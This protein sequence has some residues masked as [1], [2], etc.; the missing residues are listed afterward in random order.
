MKS[1]LRDCLE[2]WRTIYLDACANCA[3]KVSKRDIKTTVSRVEEEGMSFLTITLPNFA[4]DFEYSLEH[5]MVD[6]TLFR[7]FRKTAAIPAFLQGMLGRIFHRD[8]GRINDDKNINSPN[9]TARLVA[10][11]RQICL[12][13]KKIE[14]PCTPER[15]FAALEN[16]IAV[17]NSFELFTLSGEDVEAFAS[18]SS[19]LW[20]DVLRDLRMDLLL[21]RHGPGA[22]SERISGNQKFR[23]KFWHDRLEPFLSL[24]SNAYP[25][26]LW[27]RR[28]E[29]EELERVSILSS[30]CELPVR[31]T[32]VPKTLKGPRI[33]AIEPCCMQYAQQGLRSIIYDAIERHRW[34]SGHINFRDQS[35]NQS[36][37]IR[38]SID[39]SLSTI[40][41]SDASDRVPLS[42]AL[43]MFDSVPDIRDFINAC[44]STHAKMPDGRIVGPL[45]KF[46]S[47]GSALCFPVEAMYFYTIC[48]VALT[49]GADLPVDYGTIRS[50]CRNIY[51]YGDDIIVPTDMTATVL[52]Y[53]KKYNCKV[54][55]AKTFY[56]GFFRESC[57]VDS[58]HGTQVQPTYVGT[59]L[60]KNRRQSRE[61]VST[62]ET[63]NQ[64]QENGYVRTSQYLF[65]KVEEVFGHLP[66]VPVDSPV[67][68]RNHFYHSSSSFKRRWNADLQCIE[69]FVSVPVPVYRTDILDGYAALQK[70]LMRLEGNRPEHYKTRPSRPDDKYVDYIDSIVAVD[71]KHLER[72]ARH[73]VVATQR[74]WV[75]VNLTVY[76]R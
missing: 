65:H 49:K 33:I 43:S 38:A 61:F 26:S 40:D 39:R 7:N 75:P 51:V 56:R 48:V 5:G 67:I 63:A 34:T 1:H 68:G 19:M 60:P 28:F 32:P 59:V 18:V 9:D 45:R 55:A 64:F 11:V 14:L 8:T 13:F 20:S 15:E 21:P 69:I 36:L 53:L 62:V 30:D 4:R 47:M 41:L 52:D 70:C 73:G 25:I 6:P 3:V 17:E 46:A 58:Y 22:T 74:R 12:A 24:S 50:A 31:V 72:S 29:R 66:S 71:E 57:G 27:E 54:N 44:R 2:V 76:G 42:L 37:A 35:I 16:F 23:W 10:C